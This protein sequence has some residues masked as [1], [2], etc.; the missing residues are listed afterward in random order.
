VCDHPS[1]TNGAA[2]QCDPPGPNTVNC[3][4]T[5]LPD[6]SCDVIG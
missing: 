6:C 3:P 5:C 2:E 1:C 4:N